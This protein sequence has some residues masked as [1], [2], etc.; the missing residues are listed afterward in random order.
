MMLS[1]IGQKMAAMSGLRSIMDDIAVSIENADGE[2]WINLGVGNPAPIPQAI[3]MWRQLT[4]QAIS[5]EFEA[6]SGSYG[7]SRGSPR[8]IGAIVDYFNRKYHWGIGPAN[9]VVGPG[10]QLLCFIAA[11]IFTDGGPAS[12][13][14]LPL[15]P[16][17]TGYQ[18]LCLHAEGVG[19]IEP[20]IER[21][22]GRSF[23]YLLDR[24]AIEA[25]GDVGMLLLSSPSNPAGRSLETAE[26]DFLVRDSERRGIPLLIDN[27]YGEPFPCIGRAHF[28][29]KF[30]D[31]V[32]NCFSMS[33][34]GLPG[35]R[36]GFA[37]A[38]EEFISP[39]VSF[40]ANSLLHA[41]RLAQETAA[42][43]L[44]SGRLTTLSSTVISPFYA[45]R[46]QLTRDLLAEIL[47]EDVAWRVH[48]A[49]GGMFC[50]LWIEEPWFDDLE[51]Y[52]R[53]KRKRVFIAPGRSFFLDAR[54]PSRTSWHGT[55]CFRIS[56]SAE[57]PQLAEGIRRIAEVLR[58]L[59]AE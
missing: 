29:P 19:G 20:V 42:L 55:Q 56:L 45:H 21:A 11:A 32:I 30:S 26:M 43:A 2:A 28:P 41:S 9:V 1:P 49:A 58:E 4:E 35:E 40:L 31:T 57:E 23:R 15:T 17:Y 25:R 46:R 6:A 16:D 38:P 33:K 27:A 37:V 12:R 7:P 53:L 51:L 59:R 22:G 47:P 36:I 54:R 24:A 13:V 18:G 48:A 50:W 5:G 8:L 14:I 10:S 39:M 44:R 34:A 3:T 52:Q